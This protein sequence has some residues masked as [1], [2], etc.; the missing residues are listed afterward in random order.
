M[1]E[2]GLL[3]RNVNNLWRLPQN[4]TVLLQ[5]CSQNSF[6]FY[7]LKLFWFNHPWWTSVAFWKHFRLKNVFLW[8]STF[9]SLLLTE[10]LLAWRQNFHFRFYQNNLKGYQETGCTF[11]K[12]KQP[13]PDEYLKAKDFAYDLSQV[14]GKKTKHLR[15]IK[16]KQKR[17]K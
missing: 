5:T 9:A 4:K 1:K 2:H 13:P 12:E 3:C 7:L 6:F 8:A 15:K 10:V 17:H 14:A 11:T 16:T